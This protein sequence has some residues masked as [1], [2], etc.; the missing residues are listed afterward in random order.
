MTKAEIK[1]M[2]IEKIQETFDSLKCENI[3]DMIT[4]ED[5][6]EYMWNH[7]FGQLLAEEKFN[8]NRE[9]LIEEYLD[10]IYD[11]I[12]VDDLED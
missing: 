11:E 4:E 10:E 6:Y 2:M 12:D 5:V 9:Y 8:E 7:D 1:T 3:E